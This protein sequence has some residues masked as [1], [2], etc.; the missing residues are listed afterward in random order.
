MYVHILL[1]TKWARHQNKSIILGFRKHHVHR[2]NGI[3]QGWLNVD[4]MLAAQSGIF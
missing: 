1:G 3:F 2:W 4:K